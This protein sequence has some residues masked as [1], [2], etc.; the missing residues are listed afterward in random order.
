MLKSSS[1][2]HYYR[3]ILSTLY[4]MNQQYCRPQ[5]CKSHSNNQQPKSENQQKKKNNAKSQQLETT[6]LQLFPI[7]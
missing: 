5:L 4:E 3:E 1:I 7:N 6:K 2:T